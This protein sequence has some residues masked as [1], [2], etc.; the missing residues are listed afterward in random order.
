MRETL[1]ALLI[2]LLALGTGVA[3]ADPLP[4]D[5]KPLSAKSIQKIY[6]GSTAH[7]STSTAYFAPDGTIK[8]TYGK[9]AKQGIFWGKWQVKGNE[10]CMSGLTGIGPG[11]TETWTNGGDCWKWWVDGA[12]KPV[13]LWSRHYDGTEPDLIDGYYG[14]ELGKIKRGDKVSKTFDKL[15]AKMMG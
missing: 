5:A 11:D 9:G 12:K 1:S 6:A 14:S 4:G 3:S 13:T 15:Y 10:I 8:A 7:W 2:G